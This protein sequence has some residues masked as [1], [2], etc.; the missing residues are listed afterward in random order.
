LEKSARAIATHLQ[1]ILDKG[2]RAVL[3]YGP[4]LNFIK[5]FFGCLYA[6]VIAVPVYAPRHQKQARQIQ[7][8]LLDAQPGALLTTAAESFTLKGM[9]ADMSG[10][11]LPWVETDRIGTDRGDD[12]KALDIAGG[13]VAYLQYTSGSTSA[14]KGAV[15]T[16]SNVLANLQH[17]AGQGGFTGSTVSVTWLPHFHDM[18]LVFG[19]LQPLFSNF[20]AYLFS[21]GAFI[22]RPFRWLNAISRY[23]GSHC[24]GPNFAYEHCLNRVS[25]AEQSGLDLSSWCVA[26]NGSEPIRS[27]TLDRF[28]E[29]FESCGFR[30]T[31]FYPVYG[32]A[33]ATLKVTSVSPNSGAVVREVR[34]QDRGRAPFCLASDRDGTRSLVGCGKAGFGHVLAIVDPERRQ[35]TKPGTAGEIW[36]SGPSI[37]QGYWNQPEES[38][39]IFQAKLAKNGRRF[40]LRSGDLGFLHQ[41][42]LFVIGRI[43]DCIIIRG[44]NYYPQDLEQTVEESH[45]AI[46]AGGTAALSAMIE[47]EERLVVMA[48]LRRSGWDDASAVTSQIRRSIAETHELQVYAVELVPPGALHR[49]SS[50]KI[51][52]HM[53]RTSFLAGSLKAIHQWH[54][55]V[56]TFVSNDGALRRDELLRLSASSRLE[57][58]QDFVKQ[59]IGCLTGVPGT[60]VHSSLAPASLGMDSMAV[61]QTAHRIEEILGVVVAPAVIMEAGSIHEISGVIAAALALDAV[62]AVSL[63]E[64]SNASF[65]L[66]YGQEALWFLQQVRPSTTAWNI[67]R[68]LEI[69]GELDE[70]RLVA[71]LEKLLN[72]NPVLRTA[73]EV[74]SGVPRQRV[75]DVCKP[76]FESID[77]R[78]WSHEELQARLAHDAASV[79]RLG[80]LPPFR[81][82]L[83]CLSEQ[84]CILLL[85]IHHIISDLWSLRLIYRQLEELYS[86]GECRE[87]Q[88]ALTYRDY[89]SW[90]QEV[91]GQQGDALW[92]HWSNILSGPLPETALPAEWTSEPG[93]NRIRQSCTV[94]IA[95]DS[96]QQIKNLAAACKT[97][98]FTALFAAFFA[99]LHRETAA[100]DLMIGTPTHGRARAAFRNIAGYFVNMLPVRVDAGGDPSFREFLGTVAAS[101]GKASANAI[102]PFPVIVEKLHGQRDEAMAPLVRTMFVFYGS[103][104]ADGT[105]A[106]LAGAETSAVLTFAEL[107]ARV[108]VVQ[109]PMTQFDLTLKVV[110]SG[111]GLTAQFEYDSCRYQHNSIARV[112]SHFATLCQSI[113]QFP[114]RRLSELD[115]LP[116]PEKNMI[117]KEWNATS[118]HWGDENHATLDQLVTAQAMRTPES[119]AVSFAGATL[120]YRELN[121]QADRLACHL[122]HQYSIGPESVVAVCGERSLEL[123]VALLGILKSGAAYMPLSPDHP[124]ERLEYMLQQAC[125]N[126][127]LC[128]PAHRDRFKNQLEVLPLHLPWS[129]DGDSIQL[130]D[131][132][133]IPDSLAYVIYTSGSTGKPKGA[134]LTHDGIINR[135]LWMKEYCRIQPDDVILQKTPFVFDVSV[136]EFFLP[137]IAGAR[138]VLA[139][140]GEHRSPQ[141]LSHIIRRE[142]VTTVHFVPRM[143]REVLQETGWADSPSLRRVICSGETLSADTQDL[144][145]KQS[146]AELHNLYGPT[147]TSVDVTAWQCVPGARLQ[148]VP[149]G[150]PVANTQLYILD[151]DLQPVPPGCPGDLYIGGRALGRGYIHRPDLT[152]VVFV[153]DPFSNAAGA[154]IYRTG[155]LARYQ[156]HGDIEFI[157]RA[158][159]QIKVRGIRIELEEIEMLLRQQP[160][161]RECAVI[162]DGNKESIDGLIALIVVEDGAKFSLQDVRSSLEAALPDYMIPGKFLKLQFLPLSTNG[163]L[164]YGTISKMNAE[165]LSLD[166]PAAQPETLTPT[167]A[168]LLEIWSDLLGQPISSIHSNFFALGGH[169]LLATR[170][171]ALIQESLGAE[172]ALTSIFSGQ[173][174]IAHIASIIDETS[175]N[176]TITNDTKE[177]ASVGS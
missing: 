90:Q 34:A 145:F 175:T 159:S 152:A 120:S 43:K 3:L 6:G 92:K 111:A 11:T 79:F 51:Q 56:Q 156:S 168:K 12:W 16:H 52:R 136:W 167:E 138:L 29:K 103:D 176:Q 53:C 98:L 147:E 18:G 72:R 49:T 100:D 8:I 157:G 4:G 119:P 146:S 143:L 93:A 134:M 59:E 131:S 162:A 112:S 108:M 169:S 170:M 173:A 128:A 38:R 113:G 148:T 35:R 36:I 82:S 10:P 121:D 126:L 9:F 47:G 65:P 87:P 60:E 44:Q 115:V 144:F 13:D 142:G 57:R 107:P 39:R 117:L 97:S 165:L 85:S 88:L 140:P 32:L 154:R 20:P 125:A 73:F 139:A 19:L 141:Y 50:G 40:Y 160:G 104:G 114:D 62:P 124:Q 122:V 99:L 21:P 74:V 67:T 81:V 71:A 133:R 66:S 83:Y 150:K 37:A 94:R 102:L 68:A 41:G 24:G 172:I 137:L 163:K 153:P 171:A 22:Q 109:E 75:L 28:A 54:A 135:L 2:E 91:V 61:V 25:E 33:E 177:F 89:V 30:K 55:G 158:D 164:D 31:A 69:H 127:L 17:I 174:T 130:P 42:Q 63:A 48:E 80:D 58:I 64:R 123:V 132:H 1:S 27:K 84:K 101:L 149:I 155:D 110:G 14:P 86:L 151:R 78:E 70:N 77:A 26:F 46:C 45:P 15:I 161:V 5:A 23:K 166:A 76:W 118:R 129:W 106:E 96:A 116:L 95:N 105:L 7:S